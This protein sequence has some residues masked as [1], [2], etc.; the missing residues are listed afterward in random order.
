L[1]LRI[2]IETYE[3]NRSTQQM[4]RILTINNSISPIFKNKN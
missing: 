2:Y 1:L 4:K 3:M